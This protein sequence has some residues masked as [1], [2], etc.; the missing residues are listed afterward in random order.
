[1]TTDIADIARAAEENL[2]VDYRAALHSAR[3]YLRQIE[4]YDGQEYDEDEL[5]TDVAEF[6]LGSIQAGLATEGVTELDEVAAAAGNVSQAERSLDEARR[7][8]HKAILFAADAGQ[9]RPNI[10]DAAH[11]SVARVDQILRDLRAR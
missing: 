2:G 11:V 5:D 3:E 1:M 4:T 9:T 10:S 6:I 8:L 7:E